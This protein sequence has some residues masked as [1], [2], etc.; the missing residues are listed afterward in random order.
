MLH[1]R[2]C[3]E[4]ALNSSCLDGSFKTTLVK[5]FLLLALA[6]PLLGAQQG[7]P[8]ITRQDGVGKSDFSLTRPIAPITVRADFDRGSIGEMKE[9]APGH[10]RGTTR[11]WVQPNGQNDQR[12]WFFF[13]LDGVAARDVT[14]ELNEMI[15]L[16]RGKPH[17]TIIDDASRPVYSYDRVSWE[18]IEKTRWD[19]V[20]GTWTFWQRFSRSPVWVAYAQPYPLSQAKAWIESVSLRAEVRQESIGASADGHPLWILTVG[21]QQPKRTVLLTSLAHPGEDAAGYMIEGLVA[22]LLSDDERARSLRRQVLFKIIPVL[23]PDGL[24]RGHAR[25]N[26]RLEDLNSAWSSQKSAVAG[27]PVEPEIAAVRAWLDAWTGANGKL[28][29][30]VDFH[31]GGQRLPHCT[32]VTPDSWL[33]EEF[34]PELQRHFLCKASAHSFPGSIAQYTAAHYANHSATFELTQGRLGKDNPDYLTIDDYRATG[35]SFLQALYTLLNQK[36]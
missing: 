10:L 6:A 4:P 27:K 3:S 26:A 32:L 8:S 9:V 19:P 17:I 2:R 23:N 22:C 30:H 12:Y 18:R 28:N 14:I 7:V 36:P 25:L 15:G 20:T 16:Y 31:C 35:A 11:H 13:R 34:V 21:P 29:L 24:R 5:L 33:R 1:R